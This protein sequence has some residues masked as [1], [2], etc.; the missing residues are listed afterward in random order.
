MKR[1]FILL[2]P[3]K[4]YLSEVTDTQ[5]FNDCIRLRYLNNDYDF[6]VVKYRESDLG[7]VNLKPDYVIDADITF[8]QSSPYTTK[9]WKYA[10]FSYIAGKM[11]SIEYSQ[12]V[13]GGFHCFDCVE[14]LAN[15]IYKTNK[16][17]IIDSDLTEMFWNVLTFQKDWDISTFKPEQKL[18]RVLSVDRF[19]PSNMLKTIKE[20]Y[21]NPIWGITQATIDKIED[22]IQHQL[23]DENLTLNK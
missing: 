19:T 10:D 9:E 7:I 21:E 20:R 11:P 1:A 22:K 18:E 13:V 17:V 16:N 4:E 12:I 3:Q 14:K 15:Q 6:I 23:E 8:E 5:S 2:F